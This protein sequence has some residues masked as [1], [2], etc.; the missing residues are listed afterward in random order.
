MDYAEPNYVY[1]PTFSPNDPLYR[2]QPV[3]NG[4]WNLRRVG[5]PGAW[6]VARGRNI[7]V[8]VIDTGVRDTHEDLDAGGKIV[9]QR[10]AV[11][12]AAQAPDTKGHGTKMA[13]V[14][15]AETNNGVGIAGVAPLSRLAIC[16]AVIGD[17]ADGRSIYSTSAVI[18][19]VHWSHSLFN[20]HVVS[21]SFASL[22][23]SQALQDEILLAR[24][25]GVNFVAAAGN[26]NDLQATDVYPASLEGVI[27]VG[28]SG[29]NNQRWVHPNG[30]D[31][32]NC[33][34]HVDVTAPAYN[35]LGPII[36]GDHRY[37]REVQIQFEGERVVTGSPEGARAF[38]AFWANT[39]DEQ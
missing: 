15:A 25:R 10:N 16:K 1:K 30:V 38:L 18:D 2:H 22:G 21:M 27:G 35:I 9:H 5:A 20:S 29:V 32:Q 26:N 6:R 11:T 12:G 39:E 3:I 28:A 34:P 31:G 7:E 23:F 4:Q 36:L 8:T 37:A 19:C 17:S 24:S 14:I 33:G 13:G